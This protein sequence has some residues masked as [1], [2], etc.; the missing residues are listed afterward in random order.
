M[1]YKKYKKGHKYSE[2]KSFK[3]LQ[4]Y[5]NLYNHYYLIVLQKLKQLF[6][7]DSHSYLTSLYHSRCHYIVLIAID[8]MAFTLH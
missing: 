2:F 6:E 8:C 4:Y 7:R 5:A 3:K 1:S